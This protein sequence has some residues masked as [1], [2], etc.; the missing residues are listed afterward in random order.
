MSPL[1]SAAPSAESVDAEP[2]PDFRRK[3]ARSRALLLTHIYEC[4]T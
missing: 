3:L 1:E 2:R 4:P